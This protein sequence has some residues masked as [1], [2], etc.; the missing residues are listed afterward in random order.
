MYRVAQNVCY[1]YALCMTLSTGRR[2]GDAADADAV[3][4]HRDQTP[5]T[6]PYIRQPN[7]CAALILSTILAP[8]SLHPRTVNHWGQHWDGHRAM[9]CDVLAVTALTTA[10]RL[11]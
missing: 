7:G 5:D 11:R 10:W 3:M 8:S 9:T 4:G 6:H 2:G 1:I